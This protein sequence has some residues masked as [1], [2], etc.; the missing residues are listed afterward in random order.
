MSD[1]GVLYDRGKCG[2]RATWKHRV[3][4][5]AR[6]RRRA[7]FDPVK[8]GCGLKTNSVFQTK[9]FPGCEASLP[10]NRSPDE[11][12]RLLAVVY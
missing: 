9:A 3:I 10:T 5:R 6:P 12:S 1:A 4:H 7:T 2:G 8:T 11:S